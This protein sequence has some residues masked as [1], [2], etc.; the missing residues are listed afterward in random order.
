M[1]YPTIQIDSGSGSDTQASGAGP[2][3]AKYGT[4]GVVDT[5]SKKRLGMY[6]ASF[7]LSAVAIDG[8]H[9]LWVNM[10]EGRQFDVIVAKKDT[11]QS[12]T[13]D[14]TASS[15]DLT[16]VADTTGMSVNDQIRVIGAG[17]SGSDLYTVINNI[18]GST[19][20]MGDSASTSQSGTGITDPDQVEVATGFLGGATGRTWAIGGKRAS[21]GGANS[22]KL[23][24]NG[25]AAGDAQPGWSIEF[26]DGHTETIAKLLSL[27]VSGD[28]TD[29]PIRIR[30]AADATVRPCITFSHN[31]S[32]FYLNWD[33][34][35]HVWF[36]DFDLQNSNATKTASYG[37]YASGK[38]YGIRIRG[39]EIGHTTNRF[40]RGIFLQQAPALLVAD[41]Y[42]FNCVSHGIYSLGYAARILANHLKNCG[43]SGIYCDGASNHGHSIRGN[44]IQGSTAYG[45]YWHQVSD[46]YIGEI[47]GNVIYNNTGGG[48]CVAALA[49]A[50]RI[51]NNILANNGGYG[52][53]VVPNDAAYYGLEILNNAFYQNTSGPINN[54]TADEGSVS[55]DPQFADP[56]NDDFSTGL[57]MR[58]L[59]WP[60][61][62][63]PQSLTRSYQDIGA[64]RF[65]PGGLLTIGIRS[66]GRL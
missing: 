39:L 12:T 37:I 60:D 14:A 15:Q 44:L 20:T 16:N 30:G 5:Y 23:V 4:A 61:S 62:L 3:S 57:N 66:G 11:V 27:R 21:L 2:A 56:A 9:V 49:S 36:D 10:V 51:T 52:I 33:T 45:V 58:A 13:G 38:N 47:D 17:P 25:G 65:E 59:G 50:K 35:N 29:G 31:G 48:V 46:N 32:G 63:L 8:S 53:N 34:T 26:Q 22:K 40:W 6:E 18:A 42:I 24:D 55:A 7:D 19:I 43:G 41:N 54:F 64:Q 1:A 28:V